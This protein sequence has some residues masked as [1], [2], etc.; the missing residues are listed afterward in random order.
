MQHTIKLHKSVD[1]I[2]IDED[3]YSSITIIITNANTSNKLTLSNFE[4]YP[5]KEWILFTEYLQ[6]NTSKPHSICISNDENFYI[7]KKNDSVIF[8]Q[9]IDSS[10]P[11][12]IISFPIN[13]ILP[14]FIELIPKII[15]AELWISNKE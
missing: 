10:Y 8:E 4:R 15:E 6:N 12:F 13:D 2:G 9:F 1:R 5:S 3:N 14:V 7:K 11:N